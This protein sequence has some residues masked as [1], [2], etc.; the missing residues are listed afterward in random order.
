MTLQRHNSNCFPN[1][2]CT[3]YIYFCWIFISGAYHCACLLH[4][5]KE[6]FFSV[7][8]K[9]RSY[10]VR[11]NSRHSEACTF[12]SFYCTEVKK[13]LQWH[14]CAKKSLGKWREMLCQTDTIFLYFFFLKSA[15]F[16][17]IFFIIIFIV[18]YRV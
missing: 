9:K 6:L 18:I 2:Y 11:T 17:F 15:I 4:E 1:L 16:L 5:F 12:V 7:F 3:D 10:S 8:I 13:S 14:V